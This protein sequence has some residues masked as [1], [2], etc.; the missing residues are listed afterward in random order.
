MFLSKKLKY[1]YSSSSLFFARADTFDD[2]YE[3]AK[4]VAKNKDKWNSFYLE[5]FRHALTNPPEGIDLNHDESYIESESKRLLKELEEGGKNIRKRVFINCWHANDYESEAMWRLYAQLFNNAV[6]IQ[7]TYE[8]LYENIGKIPKNK[9]AGPRLRNILRSKPELP[10][11][12]EPDAIRNTC[13]NTPWT[14]Q[15]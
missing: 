7:T 8:S 14:R 6:A 9:S 4:G 2:F 13:R 12:D 15:K 1:K 10:K 3:G 5:F 11:S